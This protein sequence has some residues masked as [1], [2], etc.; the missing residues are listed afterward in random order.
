MDL[1]DL[2]RLV[3]R[4]D[5]D[6]RLQGSDK[7]RIELGDEGVVRLL[8]VW[9]LEEVPGEVVDVPRVDEVDV[10]EPQGDYPLRFG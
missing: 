3:R 1:S 9:M 6:V 7:I 4:D 8:L 5:C 10:G 2:V